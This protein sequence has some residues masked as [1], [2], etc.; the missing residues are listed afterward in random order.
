MF[1][2]HGYHRVWP[3]LHHESLFRVT[4]NALD[5][6][7][8]TIGQP[9]FYKSLKLAPSGEPGYART[10]KYIGAFNGVN[11]AGSAIGAMI[12]A[13]CADKF[14]RK[15]TIQG[16]AAVLILGAAIC[17]GSVDVGMFLAG[18]LINGLGIGALVSRNLSLSVRAGITD[19]RAGHGHPHVP[20]RSLHTRISRLHGQHARSYVRD[21]LY[22]IRLVGL[23]RLLWH[24]KRFDIFVAMA[25]PNSVPDGSS[26][27]TSCRF[28][29]APVQSPLAHR[30]ESI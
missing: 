4:T 2:W 8:S 19:V 9:S 12:C 6:A 13:Y 26:S 14:G 10:A 27:A 15:K 30:T 25:I 11:A 20:G 21:R 17:A 29:L 16:A 24:S 23:R 18:R 22:S 3:Y 28:R 5:S 7:R 1:L